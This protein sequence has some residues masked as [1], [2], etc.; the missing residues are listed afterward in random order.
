MGC[1]EELMESGI[2]RE[3]KARWLLVRGREYT[4]PHAR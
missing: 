3:E 2:H 1:E 4:V